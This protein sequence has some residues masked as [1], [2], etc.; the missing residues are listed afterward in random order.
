MLHKAAAAVHATERAITRLII[1][2]FIVDL[3]QINYGFGCFH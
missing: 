1:G 3:L 2:P